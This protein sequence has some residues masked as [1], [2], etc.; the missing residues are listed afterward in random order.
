MKFDRESSSNEICL[1]LN[2]TFKA[3]FFKT[4]LVSSTTDP[5]QLFYVVT[6]PQPQKTPF[7]IPCTVAREPRQ[8]GARALI[9]L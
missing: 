9:K 6:H 3:N 8:K 5:P 7:S 2:E 4:I 1:K